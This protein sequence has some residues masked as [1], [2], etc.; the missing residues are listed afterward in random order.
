M[1]P[2]PDPARPAFVAGT[3][4][5]FL[6]DAPTPG[7]VRG[8][9]VVFVLG[10]PG[11]GKTSVARWLAGDD[12]LELDDDGLATAVQ[13]RVRHRAWGDAATNLRPLV[14]EGPCFLSRRVG[15]AHAVGELLNRRT[16]HGAR[17]IVTEPAD[18]STMRALLEAIAVTDR[19]TVL[20]RF[21]AGRGRRRFALGVC[22]ELGLDAGLARATTRLEP[23][24]YAR[25]RAHLEAHAARR[26]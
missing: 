15:F 6:G 26:G 19:A 24:S 4:A 13:A 11:S 25:A 14:I 22:E 9:R 17:T 7:A 16:D 20:L 2:S 12:R 8:R 5:A 10:P 18:G 21:P 3:S 23:W 1:V